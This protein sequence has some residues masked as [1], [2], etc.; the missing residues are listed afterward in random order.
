[1]SRPD[2]NARP[3]RLVALPPDVVALLER[4]RTQL[5][6]GHDDHAVVRAALA[7]LEERLTDAAWAEVWL[8]HIR[9]P[10]WL[11]RPGAE[12]TDDGRGAL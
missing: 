7:A 10:D 4:V 11:G 8:G 5:G 12:R 3:S 1:M 2:P 6:G 9:P